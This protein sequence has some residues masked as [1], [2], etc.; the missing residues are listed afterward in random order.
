[1]VAVAVPVRAASEDANDAG[2]G[3][4]GEAVLREASGAGVVQSLGEGAGEPDVLVE[5]ADGSSPASPE[6]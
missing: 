3:P 2:A 5:L 6:N 1:L 4:L